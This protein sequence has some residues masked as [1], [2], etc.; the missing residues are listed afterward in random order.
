MHRVGAAF[1]APELS[2]LMDNHE[3]W[4]AL[5]KD[6]IDKIDL[7]DNDVVISV[8]PWSTLIAAEKLRQL[9]S[10]SFL[11]D[12]SIDFA[13]FPVVIDNRINAYIGGGEIAPFPIRIRDRCHRFGV[14]VPKKFVTKGYKRPDRLIVSGG[15]DGF[16]S[17]R[18]AEVLPNVVNA[19]NPCEID[20]LSPTPSTRDVWQKTTSKLALSNYKI[21]DHETDISMIL[22]DS[23]W[24]LTKA[25]GPGV[26]E[27]LVAGCEL[28]LVRSGVF[29]E[30]DA[31]DALVGNHVAF[32]INP[33]LS[34]D[35]LS[36]NIQEWTSNRGSLALECVL[37]A[38]STWK[39]IEDG[40]T[41]L[42]TESL[43]NLAVSDLL[44]KLSNFELTYNYL[45]QTTKVLRAL[46]EDWLVSF[47]NSA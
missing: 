40:V 14:P 47:E 3:L 6:L 21:I 12:Y 35:K 43:D 9:G 26:S 36:L 31:R 20:L 11:I 15:T 27:G 1:G 23:K 24:Y 16:S 44:A 42:M 29:W 37:A 33:G 41:N 5:V 34:N 45:P 46:L 8:H 7:I 13:R 25:S 30:D 10:K 39:F 19:L 28:L 22:K 17:L 38:S 2:T 18:L 4:Q 32:P